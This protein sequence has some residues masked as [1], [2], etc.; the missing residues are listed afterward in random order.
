MVRNSWHLDSPV[1]RLLFSLDV[2]D[3]NVNSAL[4]LSFSLVVL[5]LGPG[6]RLDIRLSARLLMKGNIKLK[7]CSVFESKYGPIIPIM[8]KMPFL[9]KVHVQI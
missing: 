1:G 6:G 9:T 5:L 3:V 4:L 7:I 2:V 8:F